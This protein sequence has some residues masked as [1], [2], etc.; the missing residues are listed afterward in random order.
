MSLRKRAALVGARNQ[1]E[2]NRERQDNHKNF[3][4]GSIGIHGS[5]QPKFAPPSR[6]KNF[7]HLVNYEEFWGAV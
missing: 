7:D 2:D 6:S 5:L 3:G 1:R 4:Q